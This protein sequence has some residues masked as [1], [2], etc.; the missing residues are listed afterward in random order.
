MKLTFRDRDSKFWKRMPALL[1]VSAAMH[2]VT[3]H[4]APKQIVKDFYTASLPKKEKTDQKEHIQR[5]RRE[6]VLKAREDLENGTLQL[7]K[8]ILNA[9]AL[10]FR[11]EGKKF[12][13]KQAK[14]RY[15]VFLGDLGYEISSGRSLPESVP[16][17]LENVDYYGV[18]GGR[19][20]DALLEDGGSCEQL[21]HLAAA[22]TYDLGYTEQ[23]FI[24]VYGA[25]KAGVGHTAPI[26]ADKGIEYDLTAGSE[27]DGKGT[28]IP[29]SY[30]IEAYAKAH[31]IESDADFVTDKG[32]RIA[33]KQSMLLPEGKP[34]GFSYPGSKDAFEGSVP[35]F[36]EHGFK[37]FRPGRKDEP[38]QKEAGNRGSQ[39]HNRGTLKYYTDFLN[40]ERIA[41]LNPSTLQGTIRIHPYE[42][43]E[44]AARK[45]STLIES[46]R[47]IPI[48]KKR[49]VETSI[50]LGKLA[51]LYGEAE[52][53]LA[54]LGKVHLSKAAHE[55]RNE[56]IEQAEEFL[57][58]VD[59][60]KETYLKEIGYLVYLGE[61]GQEVLFESL[62]H[63]T[64]GLR[65]LLANHA[66]RKKALE[67][68]DEL[69]IVTQVLLLNWLKNVEFDGNSEFERGTKAFND[70]ISID[71][72]ERV[73]MG[74]ILG[75]GESM[76]GNEDGYAIEL[77]DI[78]ERKGAPT[79]IISIME[80][81]Q[82]QTIVSLKTDERTRIR[83]GEKDIHLRA[84][85]VA[86]D[87]TRR[88]TMG[89]R[90]VSCTNQIDLDILHSGSIYTFEEL[91]QEIEK[92]ASKHGLGS[93][94]S[95]NLTVN[96]ID[97]RSA[98]AYQNIMEGDLEQFRNDAI[99]W[100]ENL[101]KIGYYSAVLENL[102]EAS[103]PQ[104]QNPAPSRPKDRPQ[105]R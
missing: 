27:S 42:G 54:L 2:F 99:A 79:A 95:I 77:K 4:P 102:R 38:R 63:D 55:K 51:G 9:N 1:A 30:L 16:I 3:F 81:D 93:K 98:G 24:R 56:I 70:I 11:E 104:K 43:N 71:R 29:A 6:L 86:G 67:R 105:S 82:M 33:S 28:K 21:T 64:S 25:N 48:N 44:S 26:F 47:E 36:S 73:S 61:K 8:F 58:R 69:G 78:T 62:E 74:G 10:D 91:R 65:F 75:I 53:E 20:G 37:K 49:P 31:G 87:E 15:D 84:N 68:V 13:Y 45:I 12:D 80:E 90:K 46:L 89:N 5:L 97:L 39:K 85:L 19:M 57:E 92:I 59:F 41:R 52:W 34:S 96:I 103:D 88:K 100:M 14:M 35:L 17:V 22:L 40:S 66:T 94:W 101:R 32:K 23:S 7:G 50:H 72:Q 60:K 83:I 18:P 76:L